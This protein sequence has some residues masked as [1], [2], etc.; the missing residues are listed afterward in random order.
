MLLPEKH[1]RLA[2]SII[3]LG[4]F[5]LKGLDRPRTV[6]DLWNEISRACHAGE[7]PAYHPFDNLL[8]T[9]DFFFMIG[10]IEEDGNGV[11]YRCG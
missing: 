3:G 10:M 2:E 7:F 5:V 9:L 1:V 11:I 8:L 4:V 6:D